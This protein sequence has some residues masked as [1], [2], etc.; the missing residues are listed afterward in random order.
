M[1]RDA[2]RDTTKFTNRS[3]HGNEDGPNGTP[4]TLF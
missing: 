1:T 2:V 4:Y 3:Q